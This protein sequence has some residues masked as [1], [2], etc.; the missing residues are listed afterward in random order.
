[1]IFFGKPLPTFPDH[2]LTNFLFEHDLFGK[3]L[4]TFPDH[5]HARSAVSMSLMYLSALAITSIM[6][7]GRSCASIFDMVSSLDVALPRISAVVITCLTL[8]ASLMI[9]AAAAFSPAVATMTTRSA[10][11]TSSTRS[12]VRPA[13]SLSQPFMENGSSCRG[14]PEK[15][16]AVR[17]VAP[18]HGA[19][20]SSLTARSAGGSSAITLTA[21]GLELGAAMRNLACAAEAIRAD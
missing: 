4:P 21:R 17:K 2:A 13:R 18:C 9:A 3:P 10:L 8:Q 16:V 14:A 20:A 7:C 5:A 6:A 15:A 12:L 11:L 19:C 1:M